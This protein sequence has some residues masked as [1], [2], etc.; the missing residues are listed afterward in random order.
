MIDALHQ[1][2]LTLIDASWWS[3]LVWPVIWTLLKIV[4]VLLP[5]LLLFSLSD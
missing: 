4:A 2:G 3:G 1:F 5:L